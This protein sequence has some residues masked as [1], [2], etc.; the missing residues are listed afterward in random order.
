[1]A[2]T[3]ETFSNKIGGF[4]TFKALGHPLAVEPAKALR[5]R[6]A[7]AGPV[8]LYDPTGMAEAVNAIH[9]LSGLDLCGLFVQDVETSGETRVGMEAQPVTALPRSGAKAVL[10]TAF[11]ADR[12]A[13]QIRHLA[14][15]G[16]EL[17]TLDASLS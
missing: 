13:D 3:I 12:L 4:S 16:A 5:E 1:M 2:L 14:P 9:D 6:L 7:A 8:A 15:D 11:E 10:I 17:L